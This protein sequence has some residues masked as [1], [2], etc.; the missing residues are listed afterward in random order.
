MSEYAI[1]IVDKC[2]NG[3]LAIKLTSKHTGYTI[4]LFSCYLPPENSTW[5]PDAQGFFAHLLSLVY[6]YSEGDYMLLS[7]DLNSRIGDLQNIASDTDF[8]P[9]R[10]IIDKVNNQHGLEFVEFLIETPF[11]ILN[12]RSINDDFTSVSTK[13]K[14]VV[15]YMCVPYDNFIQCT[16]LKVLQLQTIIDQHDL[17]GLLGTR[18][19]I[20]DHAVLLTRL[21]V[22]DACY[23]QSDQLINCFDCEGTKFKLK[24]IP[25]DFMISEIAA[26]AIQ[27]LLLSIEL[28]RDTQND[29]DSIYA[30]LCDTILKEMHSG[31]PR[32]GATTQ[33][34][35][36]EK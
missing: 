19:H 8:I 14:S 33:K 10:N 27:E 18:T 11:C 9:T 4:L 22:S 13:G 23:V 6:T 17:H 21:K 20:P 5:G 1:E 7:G 30:S 31:V 32:Y 24:K 25:F 12:G 28:C 36:N 2:K 35:T 15:D 3:I 29:I 34:Q 16:N 26:R